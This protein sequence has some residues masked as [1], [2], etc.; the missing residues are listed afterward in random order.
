MS[1]ER[2]NGI[3]SPLLKLHLELSYVLLKLTK[4]RGLRGRRREEE[5]ERKEEYTQGGGHHRTGP[6][7]SN[8]HI[9][10]YE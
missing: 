6:T 8:V 2:W 7:I 5:E 9:Y 4:G 10:V 1:K 3:S